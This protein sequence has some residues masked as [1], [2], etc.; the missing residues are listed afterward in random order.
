[1]KAELNEANKEKFFALYWGQ[2]IV[3]NDESSP[4]SNNYFSELDQQ[5]MYDHGVAFYRLGLKSISKISD[6]DAIEVAKRLMPIFAECNSIEVH[7]ECNVCVKFI[8]LG[9]VKIYHP[10]LSFIVNDYNN[11]NGAIYQSPENISH[12]IDFI[13]SKGY[14]HPWMGLSA[15]DLE[16]ADWIILDEEIDIPFIRD[17]KLK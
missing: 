4:L 8:G 2:D 1:M 7:R 12:C 15:H 3:F 16:Q 6:Q 14:F 9:E 11:P 13:R 17:S 5:F 10:E